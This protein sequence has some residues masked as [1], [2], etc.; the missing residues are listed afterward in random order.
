ML[1]R[2]SDFR[3]FGRGFRCGRIFFFLVGCFGR[4]VG[5]G[6]TCR[7]D[8]ALLRNGEF[9][10][11][12]ADIARTE[13]VEYTDA[14]GIPDR[15]SILALQREQDRLP[16]FH[17][18]ISEKNNGEKTIPESHHRRRKYSRARQSADRRTTWSIFLSL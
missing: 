13:T 11:S 1:G 5:L 15:L 10:G 7:V 8:H 4:F 17:I 9:R 12:Y 3:F 16:V 18:I 2:R 14:L 6:R